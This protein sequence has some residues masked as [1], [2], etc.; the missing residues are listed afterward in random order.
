MVWVIVAGALGV[1]ISVTGGLFLRRLLGEIT[2]LRRQIT[3]IDRE[4]RAQRARVK[5]L[6]YLIT[7]GG[8][9]G[10]NG[11]PAEVS[12][13]NG[14]IESSPHSAADQPP[15]LEPARRKRHLVL[16]IGGAVAALATVSQV[17]RQA[18]HYYQGQLVGA[19]TGAAVTA[20]TVTLVTVQPWTN[21]VTMGPPPAA[22]TAVPPTAWPPPTLG[23]PQ[24]PA[25]SLK[26]T[27]SPAPS[28]VKP[29][30][31][32]SASISL[33]P[34]GAVSPS[35]PTTSSAAAIADKSSPA[36]QPESTAPS[37]GG[38]PGDAGRS[39]GSGSGAPT[40]A[41]RTPAP[42]PR[43]LPSAAPARYALCLHANAAPLSGVESCVLAATRG[44]PAAR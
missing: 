23:P 44:T 16:F 3:G 35:P 27:A 8:C 7:E 25:T 13:V 30:P 34:S 5:V 12:V 20:A 19:V 33:S 24:P 40:T 6:R 17:A 41:G 15:G 43:P 26:P 37:D 28:T 2:E 4:M 31:S 29:E 10:G 21:N 32:P 38:S 9:E 22:P 1:I 39:D 18:M 11:P 42:S 14:G 36:A